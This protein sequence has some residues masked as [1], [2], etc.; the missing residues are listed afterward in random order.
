MGIRG[1]ALTAIE[2]GSSARYKV[3]VVSANVATEM[4]DA[5]F[6][7]AAQLMQRRR[8]RY[9]QYSPVFW[10]PRQ[11]V[12]ELH[13]QFLRFSGTRPGAVALRTEHGFII[14]G[15]NQSRCF[16]DDFAVDDDTF[17]ASEGRELLLS[18]W[19]RARSD[20]QNALRV[21]VA[22]RDVPK[23]QMLVDLGFTTNARWWIKELAPRAEVQPLG[24]I[25]VAGNAGLLLAAPPVYDPGGPVCLLSGLVPGTATTAGEQ[26]ARAGA[27]LIIVQREGGEEAVPSSEPELEA[28]G[29]H[30]PSEFYQGRP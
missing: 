5:D 6:P 19:R 15:P 14:A 10:R 26:A 23:R 27:V 16:V 21:V 30:N 25:S 4:T 18:A 28:A 29:Y 22:R 7:W 24:A 1:Q 20:V 2:F 12:G 17:W 11:G 3:E 8:E 9:A 13:A